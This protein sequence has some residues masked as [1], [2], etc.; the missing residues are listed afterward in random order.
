MVGELIVEHDQVGLPGLG[1]F[2]AEMVP[3]SF[4]DKGFTIHPPYRRLSFYPSRLEDT[5]LIDFY[6]SS[7]HIDR[8]SAEAYITQ[9]LAELKNILEE[10]KSVTL[11]G[12]GRLRATRENAFFFVPDEDLDIFPEGVGLRPVSLKSH[13]RDE[14][15][16]VINIKP[17]PEPE[18][19]P[20]PEPE[21]EAA[22][23]LP[24]APDP[25][26]DVSLEPPASLRSEPNLEPELQPEPR[27]LNTRLSW[28]DRLPEGWIDGP[29]QAT[30]KRRL[31]TLWRTVIIL[32]V[33]AVLLLAAFLLL[34]RVAPNFIDKLLYTP[35]ELRI[36]NY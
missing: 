12:L 14:A 24:T 33:L 7:N 21:P 36:L 2:V 31:S 18:Q 30:P 15:P 35:E 4:A 23:Q 19:E 17:E 26:G 9:Y 1:T 5:L 27:P 28:Q 11:P 32:L 13:V 22:S 16:V 29:E 34:A 3:A 6:A 25:S 20:E 10:R 8:E